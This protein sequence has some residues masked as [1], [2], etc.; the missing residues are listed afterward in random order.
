MCSPT[1]MNIEGRPSDDP[2]SLT[3]VQKNNNITALDL[4]PGGGTTQEGLNSRSAVILFSDDRYSYVSLSGRR[5]GL[6]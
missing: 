3:R 1:L 6:N 4:I 2:H 5:L